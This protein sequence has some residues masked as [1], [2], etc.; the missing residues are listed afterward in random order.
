[1]DGQT[2]IELIQNGIKDLF[3]YISEE[4]L[5]GFA[6]DMPGEHIKSYLTKNCEICDST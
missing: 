6:F 4:N 1:M 3:E 5:D 2:A